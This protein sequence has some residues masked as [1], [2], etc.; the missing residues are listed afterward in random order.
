MTITFRVDDGHHVLSPSP[1]VITPDQLGAFRD[2]LGDH[3]AR[4]GDAMVIPIHGEPASGVF[5]IE[6]RVCPLALASIARFFDHDPAVIAVID[7]AQS[8]ARRVR[9]WQQEPAGD[10]RLGLGL[11][12]DGAP[13]LEV[14]NGNAFA[15]LP[16]LGLDEESCGAIPLSQLRQRLM[17]P[18]I[19]RRLD[20][21][22]H[23]S[24]YVEALTTMAA[25]KPVEGEYHLAWA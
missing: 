14:A 13:E 19:R 7:E 23:M 10:L 17:D 25:L 15:L 12:P 9:I 20:E 24:R 11:N 5:E 3:T 2:L 8:W 21:D 1:A 16:S 4:T 22:P 6:V 18:R